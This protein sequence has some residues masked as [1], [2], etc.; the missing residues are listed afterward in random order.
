[1][2]LSIVFNDDDVVCGTTHNLVPM[3]RACGLYQPVW[4]ADNLLG[5]DFLASE[6]VGRLEHGLKRLVDN[7]ELYKEYNSPN[8]WGTYEDFVQF[9]TAYITA[10]HE[11]PDATVYLCR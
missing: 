4:R 8:G 10:C 1:M 2:G 11:R 9:L 3:A 7:E 6:V 5:E